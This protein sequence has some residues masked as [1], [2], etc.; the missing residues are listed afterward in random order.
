M[1]KLTKTKLQKTNLLIE[2]KIGGLDLIL[3]FFI[4]YEYNRTESSNSNNQSELNQ[5][6]LICIKILMSILSNLNKYFLTKIY[7]KPAT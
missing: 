2:I 6:S 4:F 3:V 5:T 7:M 1:I